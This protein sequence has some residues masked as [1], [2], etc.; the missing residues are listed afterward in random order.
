M[1]L[2]SMLQGRALRPDLAMTGE[3]S[4]RGRILP[5]GGIKEKVLAA[6]RAGITHIIL[7]EKN[8]VDL[9]EIPEEVKKKLVF[10]TVRNINQASRYIQQLG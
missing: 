8:R 5:V 9:K 1:A 10:K 2:L 6:A 4:L 3:I 7:P